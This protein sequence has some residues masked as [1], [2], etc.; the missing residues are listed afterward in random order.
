M[1]A[2]FFG[3]EDWGYHVML[4]G[5][6]KDVRYL[7]QREKWACQVKAIHPTVSGR[8]GQWTC[9]RQCP[10]GCPRSCGWTNIS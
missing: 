4:N 9:C 2:E 10:V 5:I 7:D 3:R 1:H 6:G 8:C